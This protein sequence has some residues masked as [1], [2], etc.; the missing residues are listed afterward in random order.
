MNMLSAI[1]CTG[2][3][4][5]ESDHGTT[6]TI[7][8]QDDEEFDWFHFWHPVVP[9]DI[10]DAEKPHSFHLLGID[11]VVWN[12]GMVG[13]FGAKNPYSR[14]EK[15]NKGTWHAFRD[16]CPHRKV[17]LSE[18][19][20]E[21]D[22]TLLCSY[23]AW[24]FN[25]QGDCVELPQLN[26]DDASKAAL[27][28]RAQCMAFP[29]QIVDGVLYVWPTLGEDARLE[30]ALTPV[31]H[32]DTTEACFK[33]PWNFR[34]L[35]YGADFFIENVV[36]VAHASCAHHNIVRTRYADQEAVYVV[37]KGLSKDGFKVHVEAV[38][39]RSQKNLVT[40]FKAPFLATTDWWADDSGARQVFELY[41]SPSRPGYSNHM[42]RTV[43]YPGKN[44]S[45]PLLYRLFMLPIPIWANHLFGHVFLNQDALL[46]HLQERRMAAL[47]QYTS[48]LANE[49]DLPYDYGKAVL[50]VNSDHSPFL[51]RKWLSRYSK[52]RI[53][54]R[55]VASLPPVDR[56]SVFDVWSTHTKHCKH[57]QSAMRKTRW[58]KTGAIALAA[59]IA[60]VH[61]L[62][63][64]WLDLLGVAVCGGVGMAMHELEGMFR[65]IEFSHAHND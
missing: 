32:L 27:M 51:Y 61:P 52:G 31:V 33:S 65:R 42:G 55:G 4:D 62:Q 9:V 24:R 23:H 20:V 53:P 43:I 39:D 13:E 12:D 8:E 63:Q 45:L 6:L 3:S 17:P 2:T 19:R 41:V 36:D 1:P 25:G 26:N 40:E 56:D 5:L 35:P 50:R 34:E 46:L 11:L 59:T 29:T 18:G 7:E 49:D 38:H 10:L 47:H 60:V 14:T 16:E 44:G 57:C 54:Y 58:V 64:E 15:E 48:V 28:Q 37:E 30:A 21:N 22:G